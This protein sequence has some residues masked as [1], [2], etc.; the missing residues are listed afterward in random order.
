MSMPPPDDG[1]KRMSPVVKLALVG[2]GSAALLYSC[3]P[4]VGGLTALP[5]IMGMGNPFYRPPV[6]S[7]CPPG[8]PNCTPQGLTGS[9]GTSTTGSSGV[10][11]FRGS[12]GSSG[13]SVSTP[14][15]TSSGPSAGTTTSQR[16]G[17][18]G[19]ASS[20]GS[21]GSS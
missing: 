6:A 2:V 4:A 18:G 5:F 21:S 12:T 15:S 13:S 10:S 19:T 16:G 14:G 20:H 3:A 7:T 8:V 1:K 11:A 17:F 9:T